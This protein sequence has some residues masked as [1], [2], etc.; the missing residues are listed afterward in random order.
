MQLTLDEL[1]SSFFTSNND[2]VKNAG[3]LLILPKALYLHYYLFWN[4]QIFFNFLFSCVTMKHALQVFRELKGEREGAPIS[5]L[6]NFTESP[7][8]LA[9]WKCDSQLCRRLIDVIGHR[10]VYVFYFIFL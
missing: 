6:L 4:V 9:R 2:F 5:R 3:N 1:E 8:L 7:F 10:P